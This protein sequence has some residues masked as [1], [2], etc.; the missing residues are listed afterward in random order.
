MKKILLIIGLSISY[1]VLKAQVTEQSPAKN[2]DGTYTIA[3]VMP[4]FAGGESA[5]TDFLDKN[6]HYPKLAMEQGIQGKVWIGFVVDSAGNVKNVEI[7]RGIG[8]GCDEEAKRVI[9][10]MPS[11]IPGT[12]DGK[13]VT[14]KFRFPI[15]F[16]LVDNNTDKKNKKKKNK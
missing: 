10:I 11:W 7:L 9:E 3:E 2:N 12:Q 4:Q 1:S 14:V 15:N 13:P 6:L 5:M 8:G 16:T